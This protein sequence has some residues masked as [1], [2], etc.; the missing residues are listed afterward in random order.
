MNWSRNENNAPPTFKAINC[1]LLL[2]ERLIG[3]G[4][5]VGMFVRVIPAG[6]SQI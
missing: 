2:W 5:V 3:G 6:H 1:I 4:G